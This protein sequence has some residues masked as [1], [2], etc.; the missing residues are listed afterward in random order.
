MQDDFPSTNI[1]TPVPREKVVEFCKFPPI[2][3]TNR[4]LLKYQM[5]VRVYSFC[6]CF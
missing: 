3:E 6:T 4:K 2:F 5:I 1:K